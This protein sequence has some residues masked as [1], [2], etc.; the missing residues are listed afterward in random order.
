MDI[1]KGGGGT[2]TTYAGVVFGFAGKDISQYAGPS[3]S[4]SLGMSLA[5]VDPATFQWLNFGLGIG[6]FRALPLGQENPIWGVVGYASWGIGFNTPGVSVNIS[7][8]WAKYSMTEGTQT[9]YG[10]KTQPD[11]AGLGSDLYAG[12]GSPLDFCLLR[13]LAGW[14]GPYVA[15]QYYALSH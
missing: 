7:A 15:E 1:L 11:L 13:P 4:G 5:G 10:S 6:V 3:V 2:E 14:L 9:V 12:T 8:L